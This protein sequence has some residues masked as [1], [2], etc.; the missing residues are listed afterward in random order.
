MNR[1]KNLIAKFSYIAIAMSLFAIGCGDGS[2]EQTDENNEDSIVAIADQAEK[3]VYPLPTPLEITNMLNKAGA[4]Y[5]LD[6]SN[7]PGNVD[8]YFTESQKAL[9]LGVYGADLSYSATYNKSQE[10]M[11]FF[12]CTKKLRDGMDIQTPYNEDLSARIEANIENTDSLYDIL[13]SSFKN[14]FEYL[15]NNG[16][17]AISVMVIGGGWIEGLYLSSQLA[18]LTENN[19]EILQGIADQ[20]ESLNKLISI[21]ESYKDNQD[22][23]EVLVELNDLK[24]IFA[25]LQEE[26]GKAKMTEESF[27]K[28]NEEVDA[29]R[30]KIVDTP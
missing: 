9:N 17:G 23:S 7:Q 18:M 11:D 22:V 14:T 27:K 5:I 12:V 25:E 10:T 21:M 16:K 29:L 26:D 1:L 15:N 2:T 4:S 3:L 28:I 20:K 19:A 24:A 30:K 13:T 6:I 8:K